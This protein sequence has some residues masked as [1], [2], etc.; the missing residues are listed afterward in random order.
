[1][2]QHILLL[3]GIVNKCVLPED[4]RVVRMEEG[5][6]QL[7]GPRLCRIFKKGKKPVELS[8]RDDLSFLMDTGVLA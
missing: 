1:M 2:Q 5:K 8:S 4:W 3:D 6:L 7:T